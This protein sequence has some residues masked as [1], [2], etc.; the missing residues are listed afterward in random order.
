MN[1]SEILKRKG[2]RVE[3]AEFDVTVVEAARVMK[4]KGIGSLVVCAGPGEMVGIVTERDIVHALADY[5]D[6]VMELPVSDLAEDPPTTCKPGDDIKRVMAVMTSRRV[7]HLPVVVGRELRGIVSI[8][9][10]VKH[11]LADTE[12]EVNVLRDY[13]R[14]L[15]SLGRLIP[16][17]PSPVRKNI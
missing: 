13:T 5:G 14:T 4:E 17:Q 15:G 7:R 3:T 12:L 6:Q 10:L 16:S 2:E 9:D 11:R 8:G 1:V